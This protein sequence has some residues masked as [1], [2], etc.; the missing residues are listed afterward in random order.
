MT[1]WS[2]SNEVMVVTPGVLAVDCV[3]DFDVAFWAVSG[4]TTARDDARSM[5]IQ[6]LDIGSA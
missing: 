2:L 5:A 3:S 4:A 6:S 1:V